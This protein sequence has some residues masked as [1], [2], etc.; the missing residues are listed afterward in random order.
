MNVKQGLVWLLLM[1]SS[2]AYSQTYTLSGNIRDATTGEDLIGANIVL[3]NDLS[4]GTTSNVFGFYSFTLNQ[5]KYQISYQYLGYKSKI[6]EVDL[7]QDM[8]VN[9]ELEMEGETMKEVV[10]YAEKKDQNVTKNEVSV[11]RLNMEEISS[12]PVLFGE[13]DVMKVVQ[14][15]P[16][17]KSAGEGN[18]GYYV[19]GGGL[20]QNLILLDGAP[21]YNPSH[22]LGF[23]SVFNSDALKDVAMYKGGMPAEYGG[24]VSSVMDIRMK[25]GNSKDYTLS[26]GIGLISSKLTI[27][28]PLTKKGSFMVAGR[29]T[30]L[31]L[32]TQLSG[33]DAISGSS[34]FFY[35]LNVKGNYRFDDKNRLFIS[36]YFGRDQL[37]FND[38]FGFNWGNA[39]GTIRWNHLFNDKLFSNT[40]F[41]LS[42]YDY[43]FS[44][45]DGD[46]LLGLQSIIFDRNLQ[47]D[48]T[49]FANEDN[50]IKFGANAIMHEIQPGNV[51]AGQNRGITAEDTQTRNAIEAALYVQNDQKVSKNLSVAYGLRWSY[52]NYLGEGIAYN[53]DENSELLSETE[54]AQG[55]SIQTYSGWEPRLSATYILNAT[56]SLKAAYNRNYQYLHVL[57]NSTT[58]TPTDVWMPS[59]NNIKPQIADQVS[60]GYFRNFKENMYESSVEVYYKDL[61]NVIDYRNGADVF[62]ND[63]LETELVYGDGTAY[64]IEFYLKKKSGKL[65]GWV[66]YTLSRALREFDEINNGEAFPA[67]QDRI[68]DLSIVAQYQLT[69]K[70]QL[71][72]NF[73]FNTGDAVTFP[74]GAYKIDDT[75]VPVYTERNGERMPAYHRMDLGVTWQRKKTKK[76]ESS[77]NFSLYNTYGR[78]NAFSIDFRQSED[79]PNVTEAVQTSLF[80]WVPSISYNFKFK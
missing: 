55:E 58:S 8:T 42:S 36:G 64:G 21:V 47:Q 43:E 4:R 51:I 32:F 39:T 3:A 12:I 61:Q 70:L 24:R 59:T 62:F 35:D 22:L 20:D 23:F 49:F 26:G 30:Y 53:L 19:R 65:T 74:T 41:I 71:S 6:I 5:G 14:L 28:G 78:Q 48:F 45:G 18:S 57:T 75:F 54:F 80:R 25:D 56:S 68:H 69:P 15:T 44:L 11:T 31:D 13:R 37:G 63:A 77:W 76:F 67:R 66:S 16:G 46:D 29:R 60:L 72:G 34:L 79:N 7:S 73:V 50:T 27:E 17:V 38:A 2:M 33:D 1:S 52:Y 40:S 9:I 10:I